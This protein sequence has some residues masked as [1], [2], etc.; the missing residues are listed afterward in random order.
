MCKA[1]LPWARHKVL[2]LYAWKMRRVQNVL[3]LKHPMKAAA[4]LA[5]P[6]LWE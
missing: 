5:D 2:L 3:L 4:F 6:M 1:P